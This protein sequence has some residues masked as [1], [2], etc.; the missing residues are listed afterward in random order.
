MKNLEI[1]NR[2]LEILGENFGN[3]KESDLE[4][5]LSLTFPFLVDDFF[6]LVALFTPRI[7]I[8]CNNHADVDDRMYFNIS[9]DI[10]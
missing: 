1:A 7:Q 8:S 4:L 9:S 6:H 5:L 2:I 10:C 3:I